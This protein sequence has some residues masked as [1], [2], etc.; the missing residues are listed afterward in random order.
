MTLTKIL[1]VIAL[2]IF[3]LM[4]LRGE[5]ISKADFRT[6]CDATVKAAEL[7]AGMQAVDNRMVK[8]FY[9][10]NPNDYDGILLY[11]P[12]TNMDANELLI[13]KLKDVSQSNEVEQAIRKRL[14]TQ[15]NSFEGYGAE[16][17]KLLNDC[18]IK[19]KGNYILFLVGD[20]AANGEA[21]FVNSL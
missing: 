13:V 19:I 5:K 8:R 3:I 15:K 4:D 9:G 14:A 20:H 11:S 10:L 6:V 18:V 21:A 17:T 12:V 2:F 7:P 16:Q 1:L